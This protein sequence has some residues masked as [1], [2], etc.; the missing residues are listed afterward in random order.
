M[1]PLVARPPLVSNGLTFPAPSEQMP[2]SG[3]LR[4]GAAG[5]GCVSGAQPRRCSAVSSG[6]TGATPHRHRPT[7]VT[8]ARW[9][10][11]MMCFL[12]VLLVSGSLSSAE[13]SSKVRGCILVLKKCCERN[14]DTWSKQ[15]GKGSAQARRWPADRLPLAERAQTRPMCGRRRTGSRRRGG[16][17][18][19]RGDVPGARGRRCDYASARVRPSGKSEPLGYPG[20]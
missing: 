2:H 16:A 4:R 7:H 20:G 6:E 15:A 17:P 8:D 11:C 5:S 9:Y 14:F 13:R 19:T 10:K 12:Y 3:L 18:R 1:R